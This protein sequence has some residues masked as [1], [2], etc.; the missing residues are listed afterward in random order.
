MENQVLL[1][2]CNA[3][4]GPSSGAGASERA[5]RGET[6]I[7]ILIHALGRDAAGA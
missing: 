5:A 7:S 4:P 1:P 2:W 3:S 6:G